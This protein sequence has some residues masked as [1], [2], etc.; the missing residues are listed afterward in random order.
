VTLRALLPESVAVR[1][2]AELDPTGPADTPEDFRLAET[3]VLKRRREYAT[4]RR[5][6]REAIA[7]HGQVVDRIP[8]GPSGEPVWPK[9]C[10]GSITHCDGFVAAVVGDRR[11]FV[12][13]GVDA[14]PNLSLPDGVLEHVA[15]PFEID[16]VAILGHVDSSIAWDRLFFCVKEAVYKAWFPIEH[17]W[18]GFEDVAVQVDV[19]DRS[20]AATILESA[21]RTTAPERIAGKWTYDAGL[22][23]CAATVATDQYFAG[24]RI[25]MKH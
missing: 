21:R 13:L 20:F 17:R 9:W 1:E 23:L 8:S 5:L 24:R 18:L 11:D 14:E 15:T 25:P 6:A 7:V 3:A 19:N 2:T 10:T 12:S 16:S 22:L 4:G